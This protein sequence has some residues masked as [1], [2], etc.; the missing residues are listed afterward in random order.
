MK[1]ITTI[2]FLVLLGAG[3]FAQEPEKTTINGN[4]GITNGRISL[5]SGGT[6]Y[7]PAGLGRWVGFI[8]GLK[9]GA[10]VN[11]E[12]YTGP[13]ADGAALF[14]VTKLTIGGKTYDLAPAAPGTNR[15]SHPGWNQERGR[16][17]HP[18]ARNRPRAAPGP[19]C[20]DT[21]R[22]DYGRKQRRR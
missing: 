18:E 7:F 15:L 12:G 1:R 5:A 3:I 21:R 22:H 11:L 16:R 13:L 2:G 8:D 14:Y 20:G 19:F 10:A 9:E 6:T 17:P 4:L